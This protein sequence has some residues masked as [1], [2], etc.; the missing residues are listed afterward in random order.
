MNRTPFLLLLALPSSLPA[1]QRPNI[2]LLMSDQHRGDAMSCVNPDFAIT[3]NLD[4]LAADGTLFTSAY[5]SCPSS[6]PARAGLLTGLSP[7]HHGMLGYGRMARHYRYEGPQM[8]H[9]AGYYTFAVGKNHW[10]PQRGRRGLDGVLLD[11]SG[12]VEDENFVSDYRVWA[13]LMQPGVNPDA[14]GLGWNDHGAEAYVLPDSL[15]PTHWTGLMARRFLAHYNLDK[16]FFLKVSFARPHS[17]YDPPKKY[18]DLYKGRNMPERPIGDWCGRWATPVDVSKARKDAP[19]G[20]FG[21][22]YAQ[23]SKLYYCANVSFIDEEI[24]QIIEELKRRNLYDNTLIIYL[25]D[26]GD[27]LGDHYHWRKTYPFE[28]STHVPFIVK[29]P[30]GIVMEGREP[31]VSDAPVELRDV[32][33][34]FLETA[35]DTVPQD[36]DGRSLYALLSKGGTRSWRKYVDM[37][38]SRCY[39]EAD[40]WAGVTDGKMKYVYYFY[41]GQQ[42]L[43]D[44]QHDAQELHDVSA[45]KRYAKK[46]REMRDAL[47]DIYKER[48]D[49]FV[50]D[51]QLVVR[52]KRIL[53]SPFY[54]DKKKN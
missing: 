30:K 51:G 40:D 18:L 25:S 47:L 16:P 42:M 15:H 37:E 52:K 14:M 53:Y 29:W 21:E 38:H 48:G 41:T 24:G 26:H 54:P 22:A 5:T 6:T 9:E 10:F 1:Q 31:K 39:G 20:N 2:I 32:L 33:P 19:R 35:G 3:P 12:R 50:K 36:M 13:N 11:E 43:F 23:R 28:G 8:L 27:Q 34:T 46:L 44:L 7:W 45:N 17:P 4:K 49:D